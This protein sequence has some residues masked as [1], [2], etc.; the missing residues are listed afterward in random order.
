MAYRV[1]VD[2][3]GTDVARLTLSA[4]TG[5]LGTRDH[6]IA[7][8]AVAIDP[9]RSF[10]RLSYAYGFGLMGRAAMQAYLATAGRTKIGFSLEAN[11]AGQRQPVRGARAALERNVMR[12]HLALLAYAQVDG[13]PGGQRTEARL[14]R[15]FEFTEQHALQLHEV[16]LD[17]YL[18]EKRQDFARA[19]PEGR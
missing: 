18:R 3:A 1:K 11:A 5:P 10:V 15:W 9:A 7:I 16:P 17:D 4:S 13:E 6:R 19:V 2:A 14:R 12:Y 8:E